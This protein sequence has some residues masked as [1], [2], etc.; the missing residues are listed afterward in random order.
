MTVLVVSLATSC[1]NSGM[2]DDVVVPPGLSAFQADILRDGTV[3]ADEY[4]RSVLGTLQCLDEQGVPHSGPTQVRSETD[5]RWR[6]TIGPLPEDEKLAMDRIY[7]DCFASYER[8]ILEAWA[9]QHGSSEKELQEQRKEVLKCVSERGGPEFASYDE[10]R[11]QRERL[12]S[13]VRLLILRCEIL[14]FRGENE[15]E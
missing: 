7:Q 15:F 11:L 8:A 2:G 5:P 9:V 1:S 3:T 4:E 6:Y 10:L 13:E 14:M 12:A